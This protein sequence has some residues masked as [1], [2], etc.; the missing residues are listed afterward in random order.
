MVGDRAGSGCCI[1]VRWFYDTGRMFVEKLLRFFLR[2][3][4]P[5]KGKGERGKGK[6]ERE[7][8]KGKR[9]NKGL[10]AC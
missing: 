1:R 2:Y 9:G 6:G 7:K 4:P 3:I 5:G 10:K 8:G